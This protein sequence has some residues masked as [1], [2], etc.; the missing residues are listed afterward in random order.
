MEAALFCARSRTR[1]ARKQL[2]KD[3]KSVAQLV[4]TAALR[5][6]IF[7]LNNPQCRQILSNYERCSTLLGVCSCVQ[8]RTDHSRVLDFMSIL[9]LLCSQIFYFRSITMPLIVDSQLC[10][11]VWGQRRSARTA[12]VPE[13]LGPELRSRRGGLSPELQLKTQGVEKQAILQWPQP[14]DKASAQ[15]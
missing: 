4:S 3:F 2:H 6:S 10:L 13:R 8:P 1:V 7:Q 9:C 11:E 12:A 14:N 5:M 15:R